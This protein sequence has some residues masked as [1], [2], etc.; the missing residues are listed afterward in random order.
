MIQIKGNKVRQWKREKKESF[1][2]S[3]IIYLLSEFKGLF[4]K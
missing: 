2:S 4:P 3:L 1:E